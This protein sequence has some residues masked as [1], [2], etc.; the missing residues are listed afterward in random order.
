MKKPS[1]CT[2]HRHLSAFCEVCR[3]RTDN[4]H[5]IETPEQQPAHKFFCKDCCPKH[6]TPLLQVQGAA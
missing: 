4:V 3:K 1:L 5:V 6:G 2:P